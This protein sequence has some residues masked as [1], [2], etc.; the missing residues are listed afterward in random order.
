[1]DLTANQLKQLIRVQSLALQNEQR[2]RLVT[3]QHISR[4]ARQSS[5]TR[6]STLRRVQRVLDIIEAKPVHMHTVR[7]F[8]QMCQV[9]KLHEGDFV[10]PQDPEARGA[11][12]W[13]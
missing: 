5:R 9:V 3:H 13:T 2:L 1:M 8:K 11:L 10:P 7:E 6:V 4:L 12:A